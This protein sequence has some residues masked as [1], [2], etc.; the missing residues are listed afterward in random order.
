MFYDNLKT[1]CS[2]KGISITALLKELGISSA[3]GT[4]WK[5]GS[6]PNGDILIEISNF[7]EVST[8]YLLTGKEQSI[9]KE[10]LSENERNLL[11]KYKQLNPTNKA[12]ILERIDTLLEIE[13]DNDNK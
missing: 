8:D 4:F 6:Y 13:K 5:R 12:K 11:E 9:Q 2:N 10:Q 3:N 7:L 1:A